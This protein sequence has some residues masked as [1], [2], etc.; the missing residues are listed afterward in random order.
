MVGNETDIE[1]SNRALLAILIQQFDA[2]VIRELIRL[3]T[4]TCGFTPTTIHDGACCHPN[5]VDSLILNFKRAFA[6][7][8][9]SGEI[10]NKK[11]LES[12]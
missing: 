11:L 4:E 8:F 1:Q 3:C 9:G 6:N 5:D 2:A 7:V 10:T 12:V